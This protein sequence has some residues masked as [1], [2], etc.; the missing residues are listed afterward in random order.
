MNEGFR[1][2]AVFYLSD[3][4]VAKINLIMVDRFEW[5]KSKR[6]VLI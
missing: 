2:I 4:L 6:D 5:G 3:R 1:E